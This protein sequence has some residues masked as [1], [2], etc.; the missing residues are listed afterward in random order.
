MDFD[1]SKETVMNYTNGHNTIVSN[2]VERQPSIVGAA[3]KGG[4]RRAADA[5][6]SM[7]RRGAMAAAAE[8]CN[9]AMFRLIELSY[10][11]DEIGFCN[12]DEDGRL[13][14]PV[15]WG[16]HYQ[17]YGLRAT[18][19]AV[20]ALHVKGLGQSPKYAP[21]WLYDAPMR[22][23]FLNRWDYGDTGAAFSYWKKCGLSAKT[24]RSLVL[25]LQNQRG[26]GAQTVR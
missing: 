18:E 2:F 10:E 1:S 5:A 7:S 17:R 12:I 3:L 15:P 14:L 13:L 26:N 16:R 4:R 23:W 19:S 11:Q 8:L 9:T 21:L 20:L 22:S 25:H 24:Y 6:Q